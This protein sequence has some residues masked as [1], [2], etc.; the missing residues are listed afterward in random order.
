MSA[1]LLEGKPV[2]EVVLDDVRKRVAQLRMLGGTTGSSHC[3]RWGRSRE[4]RLRTQ[5][6]RGLRG[7][8]LLFG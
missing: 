6:A 4:P 1:K 2:A 8:R 5:K 7:L 3:P